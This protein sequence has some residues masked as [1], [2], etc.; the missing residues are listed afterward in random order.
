[1]ELWLA[2]GNKGKAQEFKRLL[3]DLPIELKTQD[4]LPVYSSPEETGKTFLENARIKAKA[5]KSVVAENAWVVADDSG[6][7]V[8]GLGGL[9]GIYSARYAGEKATYAE[10]NAKLLKMM[11]IRGVRD[12]K[13]HFECTLVLINPDRQEFDFSGQ[14]HGTIAQK[15]QGTNGFGY[16]PV[17]VPDGETKTF[18][19]LTDAQ[20]N[21]ISHRFLATQ[22]LVEHLKAVL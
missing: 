6:L 5:L 21:S 2:T 19:E 3:K 9:P 20:K 12:R 1:M 13:A 4:E 8:D 11:Q 10:N 7:C 16:D 15:A 18:A 14:L 17:F 22:K